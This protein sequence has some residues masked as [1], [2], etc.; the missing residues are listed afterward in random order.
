MSTEGQTEKVV[1]LKK[2]V[3]AAPSAKPATAPAANNRRRVP[4]RYLVMAAVPLAVVLV[5]LYLWLTGGRYVSTDNAYVQQDRVTI[6]AEVDGKIVEVAAH[7]NEPVA[8]DQLLFR[9]DP[10]PYRIA[11]A[12]ADADLSSARLNVEQLRAAYQQASA[13]VKLDS[14]TLAFKTKAFNRQKDLLAKGVTSQS[15]YDEA[16][17]DVQAAAQSLAQ[18]KE[19]VQS[20][21]AALGGDP[22]IATDRHPSVLAAQ[23]KRDQAALDLK[24]TAV[25]APNAGVV[26]QAER[27]QVGQY[28]TAA[29]PVL[30]LVE[31]T[32]SWVEANFKETDLTRM[33]VGETATI[34]LDAYPG[35]DF[36]GEVASLGAGTGAEFSVLPA[37]NATGNW[38]KVVQ[39]VPV[40]IRF[41]EPVDVPLRAGL[42]AS[43]EVDLDS[44]ASAVGFL[45]TSP[46]KASASIEK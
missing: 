32:D 46:A 41:T 9:I 13:E 31:N 22:G 10:E 27:L 7:E 34:T 37:Q 33:H 3:D 39:R 14:D 18:A 35:Q 23:S 24:N 15:S 6:T 25:H 16:Q 2:S 29:T 44:S 5:G 12:Q 43:V 21:A 17:N 36:S 8:A 30:S 1:E 4:R 19:K 42:S 28:V 20:A 38:V 40:R 11:L 45:L 26:S